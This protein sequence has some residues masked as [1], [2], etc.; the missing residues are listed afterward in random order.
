MAHDLY[1]VNT[2]GTGLRRMTAP[3][4]IC[5]I[6]DWHDNKILYTEYNEKENFVGLVSM[7]VDGSGRKRLEPGLKKV[8][9]GG[10]NGKFI[11]SP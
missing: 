8:W 7:N 4:P 10:M 2:D 5:V 6:P 1:I 11:P 9:D 3:G